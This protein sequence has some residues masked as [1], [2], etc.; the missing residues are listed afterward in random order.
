MTSNG[1]GTQMSPDQTPEALLPD[2]DLERLRDMLA[3]LSLLGAL[4]TTP[5]EHQHS[6]RQ[7]HPE[8]VRENCP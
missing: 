3:E 6:M 1:Q 2:S 8:Q 4:C 5:R 7:G